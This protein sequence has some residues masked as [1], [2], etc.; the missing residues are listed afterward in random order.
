[1]GL[2]HTHTYVGT[3]LFSWAICN[4]MIHVFSSLVTGDRLFSV[5]LTSQASRE[6]DV[7]I[8]HKRW[9][10]DILADR[11]AWQ[12]LVSMMLQGLMSWFHTN[13]YWITR[14]PPVPGCGVNLSSNLRSMV[15]GC[16]SRFLL[17][18]RIVWSTAE[19]MTSFMLTTRGKISGI[20]MGITVDKT[21][22]KPWKYP[23]ICLSSSK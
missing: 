2:K 11:L 4:V 12:S 1:M 8:Y 21:F 14:F 16:S 6:M 10:C 9:L 3:I 13:R 23:V 17:F 15:I 5:H 18:D 22:V 19:H 7:M 20:I